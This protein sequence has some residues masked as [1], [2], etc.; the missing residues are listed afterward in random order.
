MAEVI[1]S[2]R[3]FQELLV[4]GFFKKIDPFSYGLSGI[5]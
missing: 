5:F 2:W 4:N 1:T 3:I